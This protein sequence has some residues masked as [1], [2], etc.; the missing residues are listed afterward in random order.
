M[1]IPGSVPL[2]GLIGRGGGSG[3]VNGMDSQ[4]LN[5]QTMIK[6]VN[7]SI[8]DLQSPASAAGSKG[9]LADEYDVDIQMQMAFESCPVKTAMAGTMGFGL[10]GMFG[11]FMSSVRPLNYFL[12]TACTRYS[13]PTDVFHSVAST[14]LI[15]QPLSI[16]HI[17]R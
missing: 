13:M 11:L 3:N 17:T 14:I 10:G 12:P 9:F 8:A 2:G 15:Y 4:Q 16:Y 6:Y 7:T 1:S 5:E